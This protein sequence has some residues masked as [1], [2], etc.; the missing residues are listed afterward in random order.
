LDG[1]LKIPSLTLNGFDLSDTLGTKQSA[2]QFSG[3]DTSLTGFRTVNA[4]G[5]VRNLLAGSNAG[6]SL[7]GNTVTLAVSSTPSFT[8]LRVDNTDYVQSLFSMHNAIGGGTVTVKN[9]GG[10]PNITHVHWSSRVIVMLTTASSFRYYDITC[11]TSNPTAQTIKRWTAPTVSTNVACT[12]D[13]VPLQDWDTLWYALPTT[14]AGQTFQLD[15]LQIVTLL[16]SFAAIKPNW[17]L[18][19]IRSGDVPTS[20]RW[21]GY[22]SIIPIPTVVG[23]T[24]TRSANSMQL[25]TLTAATI[26][27][28]AASVLTT[29]TLNTAMTFGSTGEKRFQGAVVFDTTGT[30]TFRSNTV[31]TN[32]LGDGTLQVTPSST[33]ANGQGQSSIGLHYRFDRLPQVEGDLWQMV[34][35][36]T[37]A[38][39]LGFRVRGSGV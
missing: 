22:Q 16:G 34:N 23:N 7:S 3:D 13:G 19:A 26:N 18:L 24:T 21:C 31:V 5:N 2:L 29:S 8:S 14:Q 38:R 11:P 10:S 32:A 1:T 39:N 6:L 27:V 4:S 36:L 33:A 15:N 9:S 20:I 28:G 12:S 17:V 37:T 30:A 25:D 35:G